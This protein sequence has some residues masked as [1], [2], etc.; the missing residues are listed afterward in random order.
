MFFKADRRLDTN[1]VKELASDLD[2]AFGSIRE[3]FDDHLQAINENTTEQ[4][5]QNNHLCELD[6]RISKLEE[7]MEDIHYM[8]RQVVTRAE[9]SVKLNKEEQKV[10]LM[11][12][13]HDKF[14]SPKEISSKLL[15]PLLDVGDALDAMMDKGLPIEREMIEGKLYFR[16][17]KEFKLRQAK[18]NIV[19]ID[20]DVT[21]QFQNSLL[22]QFFEE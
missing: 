8:I 11:L 12:Y 9:L 15:I 4:N 3:E 10:F 14:A 2:S 5:I 7:R 6:Q 18:E 20:A 16:L 21:G 17:S 19:K 22:Q 13:T 1:S